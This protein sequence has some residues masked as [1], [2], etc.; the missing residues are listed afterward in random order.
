MLFLKIQR[1]DYFMALK[2]ERNN[3]NRLN[4]EEFF[5]KH[6]FYSIEKSSGHFSTLINS[7][8]ND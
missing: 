2:R 3:L 7:F 6:F 4:V 8:S 1:V 5:I